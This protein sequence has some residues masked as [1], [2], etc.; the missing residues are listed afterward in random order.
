MKT[1]I[2]RTIPLFFSLAAFTASSSLWADGTLAGTDINNTATITYKV[3]L[4]D[5]TPIESKDGGNAVPGVGQGEATTFK[6]DKKI[7]VLVTAGSGVTV[8]PSADA[9][10]ITFT[11]KNEGNSNETFN[12]ATKADVATDDFDL[13][14][15]TTPT[16]VTINA[17]ATTTITVNCDIPDSSSSVNQGKTALV[18]LKATA[19]GVTQSTGADDPATVQTVFADSTGTTE[20]GADR[21]AA[22]SATN[23]YTI[24]TADITVNKTDAVTKMSINGSDVTGTGVDAPKRIPGATI[25]YTITVSN[26]AGAATAA[27]IVISDPLPSDVTFVSASLTDGDAAVTTPTESGGTVTSAAFDLDAGETATMTITATIN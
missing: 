22:H 12:F 17:G 26:A 7:D 10:A 6:V 2:I 3:G 11:V 4:V 24:A 16:S 14:S 8:V 13:D 1:T 19:N 23:T 9:Q 20:D 21:N 18:D 15:C 5:Q 25:E 27:G